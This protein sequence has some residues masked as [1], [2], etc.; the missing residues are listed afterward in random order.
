MCLTIGMCDVFGDY[1]MS[2]ICGELL[3]VPQFLCVSTY[4]CH[5]N[6]SFLFCELCSGSYIKYMSYQQ[7]K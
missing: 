5:V 4:S 7:F 6:L 1:V 3:S 2:N